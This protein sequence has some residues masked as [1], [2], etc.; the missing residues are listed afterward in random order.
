MQNVR[1]NHQ[2]YQPPPPTAYATCTTKFLRGFGQVDGYKQH[3]VSTKSNYY[4]SSLANI[5]WTID[6]YCESTIIPSQTILSPQP[7]MSDITLRSAKEISQQQ[8]LPIIIAN[9]LQVE[10]KERLLQDLKKLRDFY[11]HLVK[12]STFNFLLKKP[13]EDMTLEL[14]DF[15]LKKK[16]TSKKERGHNK[17]LGPAETDSKSKPEPDS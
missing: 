5:D 16:S 12:H 2:R 17:S 9:K 14:V 4:N 11:E 7:N 13:L 8:T 3:S 10:Q 6:H 1:Q 15:F